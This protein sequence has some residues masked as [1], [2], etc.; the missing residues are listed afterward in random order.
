MFGIINTEFEK[1]MTIEILMLKY[2][3]RTYVSEIK[4][5]EKKK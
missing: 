1:E 4:N 3:I 5:Y 2:S